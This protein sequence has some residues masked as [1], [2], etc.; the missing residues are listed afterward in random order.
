[1][2]VNRLTDK[3][4]LSGV[5]IIVFAYFGAVLLG[6]ILF[7]LPIFH[8]EG[9]EMGYIDSLFTAASAISVTGLTVLNTAETFNVAGTILLAVYLQFGGI[10]IMTLGTFIW[11]V[12]GKKIGLKERQLI[13][14]DHN[15]TD[16][17]GL[18]QLMKKVLLMSVLI[19]FIGGLILG[20]YLLKYYSDWYTAYY[21]G[22]FHALSAFTNAGFDI[23]GDSLFQ[24]SN[25]YFVQS[26]MMI[27]LILG[28][29]GFPVLIEIGK[30]LR[31]KQN[32]KN[33]R[34][35]LYTKLTTTTFFS[36]L[37]FGALAIFLLENN[38]YFQ[39]MSWHQK[40]FYSLFNS[41]TARNGGFA[42]MDVSLFKKETLFFISILMVIGASPSSVG[43]GI[44]TTTFAV[45]FLSIISFAKG[46]KEIKIFKRKI[47][48]EDIIKSFVVFSVATIL[49]GFSTILL[50]FFEG[51]KSTLMEVLF[52]VSSA[53]GTTGLS[54]GITS[55]L[56]DVGKLLITVLMF[57]GR[58]GLLSLLFL[59]NTQKVRAR[60]TYPSEKII[61][62]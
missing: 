19:E 53:F 20:T 36:L 46:N 8:N 45:V 11:V 18:V 32:K 57:I 34:F 17:S 37:I 23:F 61:I 6:S 9:V 22:F 59:F 54:M 41:V 31:M 29:I 7:K 62:G 44:R 50:S 60:T 16:L 2:R 48:D 51:Y 28:A 21:Y 33:F 26:I 35:S 5:H 25:D 10:G 15:R 1:M 4:S 13:M 39:G 56:T 38:A 55:S 14:I 49:I 43:G 30:Y 42:T 3:I 24:F 58:I 47:D 52:E 27:L 12:M 40:L